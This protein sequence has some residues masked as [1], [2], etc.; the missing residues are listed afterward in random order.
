MAL[1]QAKLPPFRIAK[2]K[3][4]AQRRSSSGGEA[5]GPVAWRIVRVYG[6]HTSGTWM[7]PRLAVSHGASA[8]VARGTEQASRC[9]SPAP[10]E[11][12]QPQA[13]PA[14]PRASRR[15]G[16]LR[17][18]GPDCRCHWKRLSPW[19]ASTR[20]LRQARSGALRSLALAGWPV[21][22]SGW[23]DLGLRDRVYLVTGG[24]RGLGFAAAEA[25]LGEGARVVISAPRENT[26][27]AAA[28]RLSAGIGAPD[29]V[30]TVVA[31][32]SDP[33][34]PDRL[35]AAAGD[36]CG[37]LDGALISVGGTPGGTIASTP[38]LGRSSDVG[39]T[40]DQC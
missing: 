14:L 35:M 12:A 39:T 34:T 26:V 15:L 22:K 23:M 19:G 1:P 31:D 25:L 20:V 6:S 36:R 27:A 11:A 38:P 29:A 2:Q 7:L 9:S 5:A 18:S 32:N 40:P 10:S 21:R 24:S 13:A 16:G 4:A 8:N 33:G 3:P 30:S 37:R 17:R 28:A